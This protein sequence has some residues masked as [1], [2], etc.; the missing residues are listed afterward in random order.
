MN[1]SAPFPNLNKACWGCSCSAAAGARLCRGPGGFA[2]TDT[3]ISACGTDSCEAGPGSGSAEVWM[4]R[5]KRRAHT[6]APIPQV[7]LSPPSLTPRTPV[8]EQE[9]TD[10]LY[11]NMQRLLSAAI[12]TSFLICVPRDRLVFSFHCFKM[13]SLNKMKR[14]KYKTS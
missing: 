1:L 12:M 11:C 7:L 8:S 13:L 6:E 4:R 5:C 9:L 14:R 10:Y 2:S 3:L